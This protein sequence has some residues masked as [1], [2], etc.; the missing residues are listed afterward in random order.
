MQPCHN[1]QISLRRLRDGYDVILVRTTSQWISFP[2]LFSA[3]QL[4]LHAPSS[5]I[6]ILEGMRPKTSQC[7]LHIQQFSVL[8]QST[9]RQ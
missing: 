2:V 8:I 6:G 7:N 9:T 5:D 4:R 1:D 3:L